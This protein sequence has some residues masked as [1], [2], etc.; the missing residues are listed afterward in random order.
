MKKIIIFLSIIFVALDQVVKYIV[1]NNLELYKSVKVINNFF[2]LTYAKNDGAA[3]SILSGS[4]WMFIAIGIIAALLLIRIIMMDKKITAIDVVSY[5]LVLGGIV[6]NLIDRIYYGT[7]V[8]YADFYI[9]GYNFP[10]FNLA[11]SFLV[12]GAI[13]IIYK[14]IKGENDE[15]NNSRRRDK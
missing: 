10:I 9:F 7:V 8:D 14:I 2:Y 11:D 5:S 15:N 13:L 4:V 1:V 12:I 6:G 3:F